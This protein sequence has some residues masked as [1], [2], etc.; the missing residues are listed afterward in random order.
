MRG[1]V[2]LNVHLALLFDFGLACVEGEIIAVDQFLE[3]IFFLGITV[4]GTQLDILH[5]PGKAVII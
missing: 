1:K 4:K 2:V 5:L 3:V